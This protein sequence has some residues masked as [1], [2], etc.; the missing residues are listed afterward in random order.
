MRNLFRTFC[1]ILALLA[2]TAAARAD[3]DAGRDAMGRGD[4][5]AARA[6]L[7][8]VAQEPAAAALLGILK[9]QG[10][11]GPVD[12]EAAARH[13]AVAVAAGHVGAMVNLGRLYDNG[14]GVARDGAL[15]QQLYGSAGLAGSAM[16]MNNLAYLWGRQGGLLEQALCLSAQTLA[17]EPANPYYLDT[18]GFVLMRQRRFDQAEAYFRRALAHKPDYAE[19]LEHLGDSAALRGEAAAASQFW[20]RALALDPDDGTRRRLDAKRMSGLGDGPT[21]FD[22]HRAFP[23]EDPGFPRDCAVPAV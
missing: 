1:L 2:G 19:A 4:Y 9:Q 15:A 3:I 14:I 12:V 17:I 13:Y 6:A 23:L 5:E 16:G 21:A 8:P 20:A 10:L 7:E 22:G 18:Y 11:G